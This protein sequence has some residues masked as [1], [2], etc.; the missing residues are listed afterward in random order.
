M[1]V[2]MPPYADNHTG[3]GVFMS[4]PLPDHQSLPKAVFRRRT[5]KLPLGCHFGLE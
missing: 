2:L 5:F 4:V 3:V 1:G